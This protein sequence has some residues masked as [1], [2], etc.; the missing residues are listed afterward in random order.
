MIPDFDVAP[1][2]HLSIV[3]GK[4]PHALR[5]PYVITVHQ[6]QLN[7]TPNGVLGPCIKP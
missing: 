7:A 3:T 4:T 6:V 2:A 5:A 1:F